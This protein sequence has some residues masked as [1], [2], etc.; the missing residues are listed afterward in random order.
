VIGVAMPYFARADRVLRAEL[1]LLD[2]NGPGRMLT[3]LA[4]YVLVF[5][6]FYGGVMGTQSGVFGE[7]LWQVL[8]SA[9][10]VPMLLLGTF[11]ISLPSFLVLNTLFGLRGDFPEA[12]RALVAAQA[13]LAMVLASLAPLTLLWYTS[14]ANYSAAVLFNGVL[15][16]VAAFSAQGLLRRYYRPL[17]ARRRRHRWLLRAWVFVYCFT[18]VQMAWV[19]RPFVGNPEVPPQ[20]FRE[21]TWGNAYVIV[22]RLVW[23]LVAE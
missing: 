23:R 5:G 8:F 4:G 3:L 9:V 16:A 12:V 22:A 15:F 13:G 11:A 6:A 17:I 18:G 19:L 2:R 14:S 20:F 7:R 1:S 21:D 10:K